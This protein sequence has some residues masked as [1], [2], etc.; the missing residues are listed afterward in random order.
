MDH[1]LIF[2][3]SV[4]LLFAILVAGWISNQQPDPVNLTP[5]LTGQSEYC[6]TC[7]ADL[8]EISPSHP[9]ITFG[10]V[11]CHGGERLALDADLAHSTLRGGRNP[12][13]PAVVEASC[14][15]VKCHS[16]APE[17]E[18]DHIQRVR[19]SIQSTYAG[20]I[21]NVLYTF[22]AQ[23]DQ[24]ARMGIYSIQDDIIAADSGVAALIEIQPEAFTYPILK[25]FEDN[26][27]SC[28][29]SAPPLP[30]FEFARFTGCAACHMATAGRS[31]E[32]VFH[33]LTTTIPYNQCNTCHNRGNY[34]IGDMHF[35]A[36]QDHPAGR[37]QDYYQPIA[38]F[39]QCEWE[40]DC[41]DCHTRH[42]AMG[43]GDLYSSQR[44]VEYMRCYTCHGTLA[45]PP[46]TRT[47]EDPNDLA[48]RLAFLNP[49]VDL[50]VGDTI[51]ITER[52]EPLWNIQQQPDKRF[53]MVTKVTGTRYLIPLVTGSACQQKFEQQESRYCHECHAVER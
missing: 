50:K 44:Q 37:L 27:L 25:S 8:P 10:C 51:M 13:D 24:T 15:G 21:T 38:Q 23:P 34:D 19:T 1:R 31:L 7:H 4:L 11:L 29:L 43:D 40:L 30:G 53:E 48:I 3:A 14:G 18:R 2:I 52:G 45:E 47:I 36:R 6:L 41:L 5:S 32:E 49:L 42:E 35:H 26:C 22:G 12:S 46:L 33:S 28:H 17:D 39:T 20:A 9:I 16:G